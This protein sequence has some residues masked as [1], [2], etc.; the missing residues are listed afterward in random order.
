MARKDYY[1]VLGVGRNASEQD[2]KK[3]YRRLAK[4]Y[5]PDANQDD[6]SAEAKFKEVNEAYEV[7]S[8]PQK[9]QQYNQ[10][11]HNF[12]QFTNPTNGGGRQ[13]R[14]NVDFGDIPFSEIFDSIF[15]RGASRTGGTG[16]IGA[17]P[18]RDIE[19]EVGISLREAYEGTQR[20]ITKDGKRKSVNIPRGADTG[21]KVRISGEGEPGANGG[22][23]GDLYLVVN[24][25][26]E[27]GFER[28]GDDLYVDVKVGAFTAMLGG[29]VEVPT[30]SRPV[31]AKIPAGTQSGRKL[32]LTGK[33]MPRLRTTDEYGD[34]YARIL[35]TVPDYLT[36]EQKRM[37][38]QLRDSLS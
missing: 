22:A 16:P 6:P 35:I 32:R 8:D 25:Q 24:V 9:R 5:H 31:R 23:A 34:L 7:L 3:A 38:E 33:G 20:L 28:D 4:Q 30:L 26:P 27:P 11:G 14:T 29:S 13:G 15:S 21:T 19:H 37:V 2:I 36:D 12:Q 17:S 18:G 10:F 1:D